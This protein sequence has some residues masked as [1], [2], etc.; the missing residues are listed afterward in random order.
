VLCPSWA[1]NQQLWHVLQGGPHRVVV[2][3]EG[4]VLHLRLVVL[5][6]AVLPHVEVLRFMACRQ[7]SVLHVADFA[8]AAFQAQAPL[9]RSGLEGSS[10][11]HMHMCIVFPPAH[12]ISDCSRRTQPVQVAHE[13]VAQEGLA[14]PRQPHEDDDE[15]LPVDATPPAKATAVHYLILR[16]SA[17]ANSCWNA[18]PC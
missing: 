1:P 16:M 18:A 3:E 14:A 7:G 2:V 5:F 15:L 6:A 17:G 8:A 12:G 4:R 9:L 11:L 13:L 10:A